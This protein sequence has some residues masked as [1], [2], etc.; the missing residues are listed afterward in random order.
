MPVIEG[1]IAATRAPTIANSRMP[2][3]AGKRRT[4][5]LMHHGARH[6]QFRRNCC[7][8]RNNMTDAQPVGANAVDDVAHNAPRQFPVPPLLSGCSVATAID[9]TR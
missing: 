3:A 9:I 6:A 4:V 8:A 2:K 5:R 7:L 1:S